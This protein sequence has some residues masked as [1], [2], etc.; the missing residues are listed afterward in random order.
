M[1]KKWANVT[2]VLMSISKAI[3]KRIWSFENPMKQFSLRTDVLHNLTTWADE[4]TPAE[5]SA[6]TGEE[7]GRLI[8]LNEQHGTALLTAARQFPTAIITYDLRPLGDELLK[9]SIHLKRAFEWNSKV[10]GSSEPF[11][12]WVED[13]RGVDI[14]QWVHLPFKEGSSVIDVDF[15]I[16]IRDPPPPSVTIRLLSDRWL[17]AEDEVLASFE[18]LI[19]PVPSITRTPLLDDLPF[20]SISA[21]HHPP[22]ESIYSRQFKWFNGIQT[23]AFWSAF[24]NAQHMLF[25]APSSSGKSLIGHLALWYVVILWVTVDLVLII[26]VVS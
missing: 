12:L 23:Q 8:H 16:P 18:H 21:I 2:A 3:E 17:G 1:S 11:W 25:A 13:H 22:L 26:T 20:L 24:N 5:L 19:M 9:I 14:L 15:V 4:L 10:H 7:L 6:M